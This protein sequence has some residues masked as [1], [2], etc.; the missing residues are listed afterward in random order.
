MVQTSVCTVQ[1]CEWC[2]GA[3]LGWI[4][5]D[6]FCDLCGFYTNGLGNTK[7]KLSLT[8]LKFIEYLWGVAWYVRA[9]V[10]LWCVFSTW[11][12]SWCVLCAL[13]CVG[14]GWC[15]QSPV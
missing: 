1:L 8:Q 3:A 11:M 5:C 2:Q 12:C 4:L 10:C 15:V 13:A 6:C 9:Q 14:V 7:S